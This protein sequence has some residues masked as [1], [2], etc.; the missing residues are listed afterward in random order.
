MQTATLSSSTASSPI[1]LCLLPSLL[2]LITLSV[3]NSCKKSTIRWSTVS[4][5]RVL[6]LQFCFP[7]CS[8]NYNSRFGKV[9]S[10]SCSF[11]Q[12]AGLS[13]L[14]I[15]LPRVLLTRF[16]SVLAR[17][18]MFLWILL[19]T[20]LKLYMRQESSKIT[21]EWRKLGCELRV[22]N[23]WMI[24]CFSRIHMNIF[25]INTWDHCLVS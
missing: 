15:S 3:S 4:F 23:N 22:C 6:Q 1:S 16:C 19:E 24:K 9:R 17:L 13:L 10:L 5:S 8:D 25:G 20:W 12:R 21:I 14:D 7:S 2:F 11:R 18:N